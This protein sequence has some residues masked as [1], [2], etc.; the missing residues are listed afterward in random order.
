LT[1]SILFTDREDVNLLF[2]VVVLG[3]SILFID[4]EVVNL[5]VLAR[6]RVDALLLSF[7]SSIFGIGIDLIIL[8][9]SSILTSK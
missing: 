6:L 2:A 8:S 9:Y 3:G 4:L 5:E 7:F 1:G